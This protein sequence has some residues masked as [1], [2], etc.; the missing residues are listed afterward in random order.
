MK[1]PLC[2]NLFMAMLFV[3]T[4][5]SFGQGTV[6]DYQRAAG[7]RAKYESLA[8]NV[9]GPVSWIDNSSRFWYRKTVKGGAEFVMVDAAS[10]QKQPV[11]D[12]EKLAA[13][14][15][16]ETR[17]KYS[18]LTLPFTTF[19]FADNQQ[20]IQIAIDGAQWRCTLA[21]YACRRIE[22]APAAAAGEEGG[23]GGPGGAQPQA[24]RRL[25][26]DGK[27]EALIQNYNVAIRAVGAQRH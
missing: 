27:W 19:N 14:L 4:S 12:H 5:I 24:V 2:V 26:P 20:A 18:G 13:A 8:V 7:L 10:R 16:R 9:A 3:L 6:A 21:D 15:S 23:G 17:G 22:G 25:S 11:F 1:K